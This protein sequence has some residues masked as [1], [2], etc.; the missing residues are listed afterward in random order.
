M[1]RRDPT[2]EQIARLVEAL[3]NGFPTR[4]RF[5]DLVYLGLGKRPDD[6]PGSVRKATRDLLIEVIA[7][8]IFEKLLKEARRRSGHQSIQEF[9]DEYYGL[10]DVRSRGPAFESMIT[11]LGFTDVADW[12]SRVT[13]IHAQVCRVET[14]TQNGTGFLVGPDLVLTNYH[15]IED[16]SKSVAPG[17]VVRFDVTRAGAAGSSRTLAK[18]WLAG[19][20]KYSDADLDE[21]A[22]APPGPNELD[23]AL[24]RTKDR[25][26][27]E[28]GP[29]G[30]RRGWQDLCAKATACVVD[31]P[32]VIVQHPEGEH[33]Q[34]A[35]DPKSILQVGATRVRYRTNTK[36]GSS[37]SPCFDLGW[38]LVALHHSGD[39]SFK[40]VW[41]EGIPIGA[42]ATAAQAQLDCKPSS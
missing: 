3:G 25:V 39:Q 35:A 29:S 36:H 28:V 24:L 30:V 4:D 17:I 16:I 6:F 20:S 7:D 42:I 9:H 33:Q 34:L 32:L 15:V 1:G 40:A 8:G 19:F 12:I 5:D 41:N 38:N 26:G 21:K 37:G 22:A 11:G 13:A 31:G 10:T 27:D 23:Y 2:P 14:A 18:D